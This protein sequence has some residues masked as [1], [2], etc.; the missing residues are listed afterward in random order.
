MADT[1]SPLQQL[2]DI[3][4]PAWQTGIALPPVAWLALAALSVALLYVAW[5]RYQRWRFLAAKRHAMTLLQQLADKPDSASQINQLLKRVLQHYQKAHPALSLPVR[6]WQLWLAATHSA[7]LP[8][9]SVSLYSATP[10][11][12]ARCQ[13]YQFAQGWLRH[14]NGNAPDHP[15]SAETATGGQR[16]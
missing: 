8:D 9:L 4:E 11:D 10:D 3:S 15:A 2:A 16:D 12:S 14:Y 5:R 1:H 6:Q 13:F 7:A